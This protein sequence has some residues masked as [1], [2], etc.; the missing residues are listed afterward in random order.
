M[1][2]SLTEVARQIISEGSYPSVDPMGA[3]S[4]D[5]GATTK[6]VN[7]ATLRPN[8]KSAEGSFSN[9]NSTAPSA[10]N[11][12]VQDL[13]PAAVRVTDTPPSAKAS[14]AVSKDTSKASRSSVSAEKRKTQ[15]EVMEEDLDESEKFTL[16]EAIDAFIEHLAEQGLDEDSIVEAIEEEF[17]DYL[18]EAAK[19][20]QGPK[21][22][23]PEDVELDEEDDLY[24]SGEMGATQKDE[25]PKTYRHKTSGK[26]IVSVKKPA[27]D[28]WE[29][30]NEEEYQIDMSEHV[31]ALFAGENLS[32]EFKQKAITIFE[33]AVKQKIEEEVA[34]IEEAYAESLTEEV[35]QIQE[36]LTENVDDY[37]GYVVE[38]W[39]SENEVAIESNLRTELTEDFIS[40]LRQLFAENYIDIPNEKVP[41]VEEITAKVSELEEKLNEEI[42]RNV[43]LTKMINETTRNSILIDACDGLTATQA[44]KLKSLSEGISFTSVDEYAEKLD[45]LKENYFSKNFNTDNVLDPVESST[46]GKTNLNEAT[47][48]RMAAYVRSIGKKLPN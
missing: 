7:S 34:K 38:Q 19:W 22:H 29:L 21:G 24:E 12:S 48:P 23:L 16:D 37:L 30:V 4:P 47:D 31:E 44:E 5:R 45:I 42:E 18:G 14:G 8:S 43:S 46:D 26:E 27:S 1:G 25:K 15:A 17:G 32:E 39:I 9:P 13:G 41:V 36:E 3:G 10:P 11:N 40:G 6:T 33:A 28:N 35:A 2:K 20:R